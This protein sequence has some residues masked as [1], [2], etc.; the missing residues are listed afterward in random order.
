[1][2]SALNPYS[3]LYAMVELF[4]ILTVAALSPD[5]GSTKEPALEYPLEIVQLEQGQP[6]QPAAQAAK[7]TV[8]VMLRVQI[9]DSD[10]PY[11]FIY[12]KQSLGAQAAGSVLTVNE[13]NV[14]FNKL[15]Q[16]LQRAIQ[17]GFDG[18]VFVVVDQRVPTQNFLSTWEYLAAVCAPSNN[19][20]CSMVLRVQKPASGGSKP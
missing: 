18:A 5:D 2:P 9:K 11:A 7:D 13:G 17:P 1:M 12:R 20:K 6:I 16:L 8:T 3:W 19:V 4:L 14:D 10:L 15:R